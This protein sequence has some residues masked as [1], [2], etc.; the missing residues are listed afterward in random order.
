MYTQICKHF[1]YQPQVDLFANKVNH[2]APLT[3]AGWQT[4]TPWRMHG[5]QTGQNKNLAQLPM[6]SDTQITTK[7]LQK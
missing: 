1:N 6:V 5:Q 2:Q 3:T 7:K 4:K